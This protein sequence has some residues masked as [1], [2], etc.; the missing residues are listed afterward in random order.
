MHRSRMRTARLLMVSHSIPCILE[1]VCPTPHR[2]TWGWG[3]SNPPCRQTGEG[4]LPTPPGCRPPSWRQTPW[5]QTFLEADTPLVL[6]P[7]DAYWEVTSTPVDR[8]TD[9]YENITLPQ[10]SFAGGNQTMK[11]ITA[12]YNIHQPFCRS[13]VKTC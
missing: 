12:R 13:K 8:M 10:T 3:L 11:V 1:G 9:A 4:G 7:C 2:Q 5:M 6:S